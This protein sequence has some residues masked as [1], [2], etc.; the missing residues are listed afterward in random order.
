LI[1]HG[2]FDELVPLQSVREWCAALQPPPALKVIDGASHFFHGTL[3]EL[4]ENVAEFAGP[5]ASS[6]MDT[7]SPP[8]TGAGGAAPC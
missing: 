6:P 3:R 1:V 7:E 5:L 4:A 8:R 2:E